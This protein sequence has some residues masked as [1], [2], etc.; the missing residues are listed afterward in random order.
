[1]AS[2][3]MYLKSRTLLCPGLDDEEDPEEARQR[4]AQRLIEYQACKKGADILAS[5]ESEKLRLIPSPGI[6]IP[7]EE[8]MIEA[9]LLLYIV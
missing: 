2:Y 4:L 5:C 8:E 6:P 1:M 9:D 3:L 7:C